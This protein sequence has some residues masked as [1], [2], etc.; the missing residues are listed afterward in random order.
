MCKKIVA[1]Y[2]LQRRTQRQ[3]HVIEQ[4]GTYDP[5]VNVH[6]E[7]LVSLNT[8]RITYWI[9][10]GAHI[11]QS[12]SI[13]LGECGGLFQLLTEPLLDKASQY[14]YGRDPYKALFLLMYYTICIKW[15]GDEK[16]GV[17]SRVIEAYSDFMYI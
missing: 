1:I 9:G 15:V 3:G 11:S 16:R 4:L 8:E 6:G 13:L 10:Q 17:V 7:K 14:F 2:L 12:C 5:M